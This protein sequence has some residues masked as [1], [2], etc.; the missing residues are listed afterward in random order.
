MPAP[1]FSA[2]M[3]RRSRQQEAR[4]RSVNGLCC[5]HVQ[6]ADAVSQDLVLEVLISQ[7]DAM[8]EGLPAEATR[9]RSR[10][11][12][13]VGLSRSRGTSLSSTGAASPQMNPHTQPGQMHTPHPLSFPALGAGQEP[14]QLKL[15]PRPGVSAAGAVS[16][17]N[18]PTL[19]HRVEGELLHV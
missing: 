9:P 5:G 2:T 17:P 12:S 18:V 11:A 16:D 6:K 1:L 4:P 8:F 14:S 3:W 19:P 13:P 10:G 7:H 15:P